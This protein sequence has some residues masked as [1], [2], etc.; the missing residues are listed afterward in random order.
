MMAIVDSGDVLTSVSLF[1]L[2]G[3]AEASALETSVAYGRWAKKS[4]HKETMYE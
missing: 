2:R 4:S 1:K 3:G